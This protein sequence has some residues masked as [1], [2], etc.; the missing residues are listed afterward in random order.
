MENRSDPLVSVILPV[1]NGGRYL[2][3][4]VRSIMAQQYRKLEI[5]AIDDGSTDESLP[6]LR[7]LRREETRM[8]L[9]SRP[10]RGL[11]ETL[12]EGIAL[13]S[14]DLI[15]RMDA[16]DVSY[17]ER[18]AR[19]VEAF[20]ERPSLGLCGTDFHVIHRKGV[21]A[22]GLQPW[23][24]GDLAVL[25]L[26]FTV[27]RHS[28]V[29][30][31]RRVLKPGQLRYD[32]GYPHAEDFELFRRISGAHESRII[33]QPLLGYRVHDGSVSKTAAKAMRRSH[34]KIVCE[35]LRALGVEVAVPA[36]MEDEP[37]PEAA[38]DDMVR[39]AELTLRLPASRPAS[40]RAAFQVGCTN[41]FFFLREMALHEFGAGLAARFLDRAQGWGYMRRREV[42]LLKTLKGAPV[43]ARFA[44]ASLE[45]V[46]RMQTRVWVEPSFAHADAKPLGAT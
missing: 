17:P 16:D 37:V 30:F 22:S 43:L 5:V 35:N 26:F 29:M 9:V 15:A 21:H 41:L 40:E 46:D 3:D 34:L 2:E 31:N 27:F 1:F 32:P 28:T 25:S 33:Q 20:R 19:Q 36:L 39:L 12:N 24:D 13:A 11:I 10:N 18:I 38:L 44:W 7:K 42:Y 8:R 45:T 14:G 6:I 4:A 23:P